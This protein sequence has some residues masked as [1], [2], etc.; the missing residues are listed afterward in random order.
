MVTLFAIGSF[1]VTAVSYLLGVIGIFR[2][3]PAFLSALTDFF[4]G[5]F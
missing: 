2:N 5:I 4:S 1:L 3:F